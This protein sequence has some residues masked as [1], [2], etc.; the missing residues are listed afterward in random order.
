MFIANGNFIRSTD[1]V[2]IKFKYITT[3]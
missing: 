2:A 3:A 1:K